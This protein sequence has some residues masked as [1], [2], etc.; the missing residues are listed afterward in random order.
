[1]QDASG[2]ETPIP[3]EPMTTGSGD[4][5]DEFHSWFGGLYQ[6]PVLKIRVSMSHTSN[7]NVVS[8]C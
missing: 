2:P 1:M 5:R 7:E 8:I 6:S 4:G 3:G